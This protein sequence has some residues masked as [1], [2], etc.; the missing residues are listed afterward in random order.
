MRLIFI[1]ILL[2]MSKSIFSQN[3]KWPIRFY[4]S[5]YG[6]Y[7]QLD[8]KVNLYDTVYIKHSKTFYFKLVLL[9]QKGKS[10]MEVHKNNKLYESGYYENSLD[11]LKIYARRFDGR[12]ANSNLYILK[13]FEPVKNGVWTETQKGKYVTKTYSMGVK[14]QELK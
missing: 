4:F 9:E 5:E 13:Y 6:R 1:L 10:Y 8:D 2:V 12:N 3:A 14:S 7:C 11:T